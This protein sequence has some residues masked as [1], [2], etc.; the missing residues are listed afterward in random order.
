MA[1]ARD[2]A[3]RFVEAFNAHDES[4]I[5]ALNAPNARLQAPGGVS[6]EGRDAAT[7]HA[8]AWIKGFP[9]TTLTIRN[10]LVCDAWVVQE[11]TFEGTHTAPLTGPQGT[12][13][14]TGKRVAGEGVQIVRYEDGQAVDIRLYYDQVDL[15][16]QLGLMPTRVETTV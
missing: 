8:M 16:T 7:G 12:I 4:A 13:Q 11:F 14:A 6:L 3:A 1:E 2:T 5:R 15:L 10:E 9:D